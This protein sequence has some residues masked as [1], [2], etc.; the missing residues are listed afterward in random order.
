MD[1]GDGRIDV[2]SG[3]AIPNR[4]DLWAAYIA[5]GSRASVLVNHEPFSGS[6][7]LFIPGYVQDEYGV[8]S[9]EDLLSPEIA[10]LFDREGNG[11]G[12]Y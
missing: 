11:K 4:S 7:G 9:V 1:R 10:Q 6:Q 5:P 2:C 8:T 3:L 12:E